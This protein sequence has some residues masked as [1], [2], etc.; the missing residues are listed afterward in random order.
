MTQTKDTTDYPLWM[1]SVYKDVSEAIV[2]PVT[3][4]SERDFIAIIAPM[5]EAN[6]LEMEDGLITEIPAKDLPAEFLKLF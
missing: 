1:V 5:I 6:L 2:M 3:L 4:F